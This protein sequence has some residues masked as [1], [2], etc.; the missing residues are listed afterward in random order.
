MQSSKKLPEPG[1]GVLWGAR[2][3]GGWGG[4]VLTETTQVKA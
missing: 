1:E 4:A 3:G 2:G